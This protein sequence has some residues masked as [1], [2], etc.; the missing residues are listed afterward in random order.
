MQYIVFDNV[1]PHGCSDLPCLG[2]SQSLVVH[3][4]SGDMPPPPA[5]R[6]YR[7]PPLAFNRAVFRH[8]SFSALS[9]VVFVTS[10]EGGA[11]C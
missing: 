10:S 11:P 6:H 2:S 5:P 4:R 1:Y 9:E 8:E 7:Q 3:L